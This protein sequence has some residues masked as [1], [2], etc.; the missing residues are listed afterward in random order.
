MYVRQDNRK[1][2]VT[3]PHN[4]SGNA[5]AE[6]AED[7]LDDTTP[8]LPSATDEAEIGES[9]TVSAKKSFLPISIGNEELIILG[10]LILLF[11]SE[12]GDDMI[13]LLLALLFLGAN[14]KH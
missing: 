14:D 8:A 10:I 11:Q 7:Y 12:K 9:T 1:R 4:Y 6:A 13:P 5:F 3:V 2:H